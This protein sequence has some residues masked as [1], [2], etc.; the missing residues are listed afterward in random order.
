ML[1]GFLSE[2]I[3]YL[4]LPFLG[5][6]LGTSGTILANLG[7]DLADFAANPLRLVFAGL[8]VVQAISTG[9]IQ[10]R[11]PPLPHR[12]R[13]RTSA[14]HWRSIAFETILVLSPYCDRKVLLV[15]ADTTG[16]R[17]AGL[18]FYAAGMALATWALVAFRQ[19]NAAA[20]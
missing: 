9:L 1:R 8:V 13:Q 12:A 6:A 19:A 18:L 10:S 15:L 17:L 14:N 7:K 2:L 11:F 4:V 16:V 20:G 3:V 5:W